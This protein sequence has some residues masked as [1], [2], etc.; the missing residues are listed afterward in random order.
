VRS[1][2]SSNGSIQQGTNAPC[3]RHGKPRR[4]GMAS[5]GMSVGKP[6]RRNGACFFRSAKVCGSRNSSCD[7]IISRRCYFK[8]AWAGTASR[9]TGLILG[10]SRTGKP[11]RTDRDKRFGV[12]TPRASISR[13]GLIFNGIYGRDASD[14]MKG[15]VA[16]RARISR[17][18]AVKCLHRSRSAKATY[19]P[20]YFIARPVIR[21]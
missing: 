12:G 16:W 5:T 19:K 7:M 1:S 13:K 4:L 20:V 14:V 2:T 18:S 11:K 9:I 21:G 6:A 10:L 8:T 17:S 15:K 3:E